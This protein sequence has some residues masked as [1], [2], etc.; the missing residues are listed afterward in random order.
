VS[1]YKKAGSTVMEYFKWDLPMV[2]S[3][4]G[5]ELLQYADNRRFSSEPDVVKSNKDADS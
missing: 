1:L 5:A 2:L 3:Q 4:G